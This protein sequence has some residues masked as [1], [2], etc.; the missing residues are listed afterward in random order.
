MSKAGRK[1]KGLDYRETALFALISERLP[2]FHE[3]GR[4]SVTLLA[5]AMGRRTQTLYQMFRN[6]RVSPSNAKKLLELSEAKPT[7]AKR[8]PLKD[9]DLTPFLLK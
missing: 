6:E 3:Y 4:L 5:E 2:E 1:P 8:K 9:V 7:G